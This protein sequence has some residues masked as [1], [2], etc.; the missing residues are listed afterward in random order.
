MKVSRI[1]EFGLIDRLKR[2]QNLTSVVVQG[3]GDDAA[4]LKLNAKCYQLF[5]T[6]MMVEDVHFLRSKPP[7]K[8]GRKALA[9]NISDIAAMGGIPSSAVVSLGV[10]K[11]LD[12]RYIE[13]MYAGMFSLARQF[14]VSLVGGDTVRSEKIVINVALLGEVEKSK[15]VL[16]NGACVGDVIFVTGPLGGSFRSGR[17]LNFTPRVKEAR[18]LVEKFKP[19]AMM[20][21]SDG[22]SGDLGHIIK[23]SGVG[24]VLDVARIPVNK[25]ATLEQALH[26]GED[27]ELL[28]TLPGIFAQRFLKNC[29]RPFF[30]V[31]KIVPAKNGLLLRELSGRTVP[32][33]TKGFTHF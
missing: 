1:G 15:L 4:V 32:V 29:P 12:V 33:R 19:T 17:H 25:G 24:A 30:P 18:F 2:F 21:I 14:G 3:I 6:D 23:A 22:L 16:R 26:E 11:D 20:D 27:F 8:V 13:K 31:G 7:E 10:P 28:F 5:T 9:C